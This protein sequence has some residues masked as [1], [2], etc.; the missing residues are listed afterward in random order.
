MDTN[1]VIIIPAR[2]GSKG[3]PRKNIIE[4]NGVPLINYTIS[5][6]LELKSKGIVNQV[7]VSTD[8][9]EISEISEQAGACV[10]FIRPK[11][12]ASDN[13]K[14]VDVLIHAL[15]FYQDRGVDFEDVVLLQPTTPLRTA[16]D[17]INALK[18]FKKNQS[19]SLISCFEEEYICDLVSYY[20]D[21][22]YAIPLNPNHNKGFRRQDNKKLYIRNGAIYITKS[23]YLLNNRRVISDHPSMYVMTK[24]K[25][26]NIDTEFDMELVKWIL[27]K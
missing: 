19:D 6:G 10:P 22:G 18:L 2:G 1:R 9:K 13:A 12:L 27:S 16:E 17:V 11:S 3:V 4:I 20:N 23:S 14:T 8:D 26:V 24:E 5:V 7:I 21:N 15:N 25:S